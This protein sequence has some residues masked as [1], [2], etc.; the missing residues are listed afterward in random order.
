MEN[1]NCY[2]LIYMDNIW[3]ILIA[4]YF[5]TLEMGKHN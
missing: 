5:A 3:N 1:I 4:L 2:D